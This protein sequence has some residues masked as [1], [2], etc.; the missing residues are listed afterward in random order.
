MRSH[1]GSKTLLGVDSKMEDVVFLSEKPLGFRGRLA[2]LFAALSLAATSCVAPAVMPTNSVEEGKGA[3]KDPG[4]SQKGDKG[5]KAEEGSDDEIE[6]PLQEGMD[7]VEKCLDI[8]MGDE[9]RAW[10][11]SYIG[12]KKVMSKKKVAKRCT[13]I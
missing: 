5:S 3:G 13:E 2:L 6:D 8:T 1:A 12:E 7:E 11:P 4:Q 10:N 9:K